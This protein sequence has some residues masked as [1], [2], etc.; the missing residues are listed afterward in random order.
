MLRKNIHTTAIKSCPSHLWLLLKEM[1]LP[2]V[3]IVVPDVTGFNQGSDIGAVKSAYC[4]KRSG[5]TR[6]RR[7]IYPARLSLVRN[8]RIE[9]GAHKYVI[10]GIAA[11][12]GKFLKIVFDVNMITG[13]V[14]A[15]V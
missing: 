4:D 3:R 5:F 6:M 2:K 11:Q 14:K 15:R 13:S 1:A 10:R 8:R 7:G 9:S 12:C